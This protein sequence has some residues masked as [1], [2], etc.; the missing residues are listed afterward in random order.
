MDPREIGWGAWTGLIWLRTGTSGGILCKGNEHWNFIKCEDL[1]S[2]WGM[3]IFSRNSLLLVNCVIASRF[4]CCAYLCFQCRLMDLAQD[5]YVPHWAKPLET[6][7]KWHKGLFLDEIF[8]C[9][10]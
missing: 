3:I 4:F 6:M 8:A 7:S 1:L 5:L 9:D 2:S 10:N